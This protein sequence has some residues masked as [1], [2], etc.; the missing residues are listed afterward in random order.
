MVFAGLNAFDKK[1]CIKRLNEFIIC[2]GFDFTIKDIIY[3]YSIYYTDSFSDLFITTMTD[4][5]RKLMNDAEHKMY[6]NIS[7]ALLYILNS[8]ESQE[9]YKVL[10]RYG[11]YL[12]LMNIETSLRFSLNGLA[13]DFSR[14]SYIVN[15]IKTN[16]SLNLP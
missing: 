2:L 13:E 6:D 9:I 11:E 4:T 12:M 15:I 3:I 8:M 1:E 14:I 7:L 16:D 10:R 5:D